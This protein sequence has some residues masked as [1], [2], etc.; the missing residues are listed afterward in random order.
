MLKIDLKKGF[1][2]IIFPQL[3]TIGKDIIHAAFP[4]IDVSRR[5]NNF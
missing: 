2:D 4:F 3:R 1:Y 5:A